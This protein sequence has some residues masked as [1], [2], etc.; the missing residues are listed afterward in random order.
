VMYSEK[1][2]NQ[3]TLPCIAAAIVTLGSVIIIQ[4]RQSEI[5]VRLFITV[6]RG[7]N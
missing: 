4:R 3:Y 6:K 1:L 5:E 7:L 2:K